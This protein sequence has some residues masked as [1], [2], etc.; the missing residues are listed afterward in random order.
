MRGAEKF[1]GSRGVM[2]SREVFYLKWVILYRWKSHVEREKKMIQ[3]RKSA[4]ASE[5]A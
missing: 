2:G 5:T 3:K 1:S 4:I